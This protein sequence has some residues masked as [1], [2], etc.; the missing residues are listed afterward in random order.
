[1]SGETVVAVNRLR[2][3]ISPKHALRAYRHRITSSFVPGKCAVCSKFCCSTISPC[4]TCHCRGGCS[5]CK[6]R[7]YSKVFYG[8]LKVFNR[9]N[10]K[11]HAKTRL[12]TKTNQ[13][14][15]SPLQRHLHVGVSRKLTT[16]LDNSID[17]TRACH[18]LKSRRK[19]RQASQ[20]AR[21]PSRNQR[22]DVKRALVALERER[23]Q[24]KGQSSCCERHGLHTVARPQQ[25]GIQK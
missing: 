21:R 8:K 9:L 22:R 23:G 10:P 25:E 24:C 5:A 18:G 7:S 4:S 13:N 19:R 1:M 20:Q 15:P 3:L 2:C 17:N 16:H 6:K 12:S 11:E 14:K